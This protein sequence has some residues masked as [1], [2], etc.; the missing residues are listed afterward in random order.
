MSLLACCGAL[1]LGASVVWR[2]RRRASAGSAAAVAGPPQKVMVRAGRVGDLEAIARLVRELA[3]FENSE[4][5]VLT[6]AASFVRDA[7]LFET[8]V[9]V[10]A[11]GGDIVGFALVSY[12]YS[13]WVG[14]TL[15]LD[16]LFVAERFR[17]RGIGGRLLAFV[18]ERGILSGAKRMEWLSFKWNSR[19]NA[20]YESRGAER[21]DAL[22]Y[23]RLPEGRMKLLQSSVPT[24]VPP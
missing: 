14:R 7:G 4:D 2:G 23:W 21:Q 20:F 19:A 15:A 1:V 18:A 10:G 13:T 5:A 17:G 9:A 8:A 24:K 3:R 16:D 6:S 11:D 12:G 22:Y